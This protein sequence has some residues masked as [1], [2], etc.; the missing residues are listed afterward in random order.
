MSKGESVVVV[1]VVEGWSE[2]M[3]QKIILCNLTEY[4]N[5]KAFAWGADLPTHDDGWVYSY[6]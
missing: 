2:E 1:V 5:S 6:T 3:M 4:N